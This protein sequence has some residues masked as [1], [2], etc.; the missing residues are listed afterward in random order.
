MKPVL[1]SF[2]TVAFL[3][4]LVAHNGK[5]TYSTNYNNS[6]WAQQ[7]VDEVTTSQTTESFDE[8]GKEEN[9]SIRTILVGILVGIAITVF[10][11]LIIGLIL[12]VTVARTKYF[13]QAGSNNRL[14]DIKFYINKHTIFRRFSI[15]YFSGHT[16]INIASII[17][18]LTTV[19]MVVDTSNA[20]EGQTIF[21]L[22][23]AIFSSLGIVL[24]FDKIGGCYAQAMRVLEKAILTYLADPN[25]P[26]KLLVDANVKAEQI[27]E[28]NYF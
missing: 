11:V 5:G 28:N 2:F 1:L 4:S 6:T 27:I 3:I 15:L 12:G 16:I 23:A 13:S 22:L 20:A 24:R 25:E 7:A 26:L 18:T 10:L 14:A 8:T 19:Y 17:T 21:L 9:T